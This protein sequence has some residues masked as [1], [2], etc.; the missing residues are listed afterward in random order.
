MAGATDAI[1]SFPGSK[2]PSGGR[3]SL[4]AVVVLLVA[5]C[6]CAISAVARRAVPGVDA[7]ESKGSFHARLDSVSSSFLG[8]GYM[9]GPLGEGDSALGDPAPRI[10]LDSFDCV[11]Y[12]ETS[13]AFAR[14]SS[15]DSVLPVLD[16]IRYDRGQVA[17]AHRNHYTEADWLPANALAGRVKLDASSSDSTD[18]R[19]LARAAFYGKRGVQRPDTT[20]DLPLVTRAKAMELF[21]KP[22]T[23]AR[24]RGVGF[25][26]RVRGLGILHTGFL[27]ER[28]GKL[29]ILRHASQAG[30]VRE[31]PL[32]EYLA[33]KPK[34]VG[35]VLWS[36]LP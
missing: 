29:P 1:D 36:Y 2:A 22:S 16:L 4:R 27:V 12:I 6:S 5:L 24:I 19:I 18:R 11:T 35:I 15:T 23:V 26:G 14:A 28:P 31:Q 20:V 32:A 25:V 17:W 7:L 21:S 30:T 9:G 33:G 34:F 10:R 8:R 13:E 3:V